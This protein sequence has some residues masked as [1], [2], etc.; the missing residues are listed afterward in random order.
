MKSWLKGG[1]IGGCIYAL[2]AILDYLFKISSYFPLR[3][4][5]YTSLPFL[6]LCLKLLTWELKGYF[7]TIVMPILSNLIIGF[8]VGSLIGYIIQKIKSRK[9]GVVR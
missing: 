1:L 5:H 3:W 2:I 4:I 6:S 8:L 7:C 9:Q